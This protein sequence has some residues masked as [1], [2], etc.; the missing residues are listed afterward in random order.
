MQKKIL[1]RGIT[2]NDGIIIRDLN[3]TATPAK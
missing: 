1:L 3:Y 2:L